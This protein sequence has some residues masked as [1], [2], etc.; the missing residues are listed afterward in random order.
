MLHEKPVRKI[1]IASVISVVKTEG[2]SN[3][4][5]QLLT[6]GFWGR[7]Q[8]CFSFKFKKVSSL[9]RSAAS[10]CQPFRYFVT[11]PIACRAESLAVTYE[12][13]P[14]CHFGAFLTDTWCLCVQVT[15]H[16]NLPQQQI[17][18]ASNFATLPSIKR[19]RR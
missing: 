15:T 18:S 12:M 4:G 13:L 14:M 17:S 19:C 10:K 16:P 1:Y 2:S 9:A 11:H 6:R 8:L 7:K 5:K 3:Y